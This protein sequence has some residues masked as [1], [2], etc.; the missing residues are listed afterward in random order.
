MALSPVLEPPASPFPFLPTTT[1]IPTASS[2]FPRSRIAPSQARST[3]LRSEPKTIFLRTRKAQLQDARA[4]HQLIE[5][6][7]HDGTL[8]PRS[9]AE[10]CANI[11]TFTVVETHTHQFLGCAALHI[12][13]PHLAEIRS[14]VV[15]PDIKGRGAGG[16]LV[17]E[18]LRQANARG[19]GCVCLFTRIPSFFK[20]FHFYVTERQALHDKVLKDCIHCS[21][22]NACDETAMA[23]GELPVSPDN[24]Q[25][26]TF[27]PRRHSELVQLQL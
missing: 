9:Y 24:P 17:H 13:G 26:D 2:L 5:S 15:R 10:V 19:I 12:Y 3:T 14:I 27:L 22:R 18:L 25:N 11:R 1:I 7:S 21:R 20:H 6:L 4:I 23:L 8:L 16:Q